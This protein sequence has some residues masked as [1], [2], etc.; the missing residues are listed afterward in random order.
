MLS[1]ARRFV[2]ALFAVLWAC[3]VSIIGVVVPA[4]L[5][6]Y[7]PQARDLFSYFAGHLVGGIMEPDISR[8]RI[9]TLVYWVVFTGLVL[10]FWC[11]PVHFSARVLLYDPH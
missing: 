7:A 8:G 1:H 10:A 9:S 4:V 2:E 3:R 6:I 11:Y 5:L